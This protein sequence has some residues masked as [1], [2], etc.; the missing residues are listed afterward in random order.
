MAREDF[1]EQVEEALHEALQRPLDCRDEFVAGIADAEI[2]AEVKSL[3]AAEGGG[4]KL[5]IEKDIAEAAQEL[6]AEPVLRD[7]NIGHF[8]L[9]DLA[10]RGGMSQVY[11]ARDKHLGRKVA[12]KL[13]PRSLS[14]DTD[15]IRRFK[16][17]ARA[18]SAL[19]H[20]NIVTV[21]EIAESDGHLF[22]ATE[23]VAGETLEERLRR[24]HI[25]V[26][27]VL[28]VGRQLASALTAA[29]D[30]GI[31][32]R[33]I[34][35]GNIMI[36]SDGTLKLLD[37]GLARVENALLGGKL[38]QS[39]HAAERLTVPGTVFGT[40]AYMSP[41][42][43]KCEVVDLRTDLWSAGAVL[44]ELLSSHPAFAEASVPETLVAILNRQPPLP[45][46]NNQEVPE[47]LDRLV[48]KLL[49]KSREA[50]VSSS[51]E[52][53]L[54]LDELSRT[55]KARYQS[56]SPAKKRLPAYASRLVLVAIVGI[57]LLL[58]FYLGRRPSPRLTAIPAH[59]LQIDYWLTVQNLSVDGRINRSFESPG[60]ASLPPNCR[61]RFNVRSKQ[62]GYLY[63]LNEASTSISPRQLTNLFPS[64]F[65]N[66]GS[67]KAVANQ[68]LTTGWFRI[69]KQVGTETVWLIWAP[70]SLRPLDE[71]RSLM[72]AQWKGVIVEPEQRKAV[73]SLLSRHQSEAWIEPTGKRVR[74]SENGQI[75]VR[76]IEI[77]IGG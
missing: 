66:G 65:R 18:A 32:H 42:Q 56:V 40:P 24:G 20:P 9:L 34:K 61:F 44:Y 26:S 63:L 49:Q 58:T 19:N 77:N 28:S 74:L 72:N 12:L 55:E 17:E 67:A 4:P 1:W 2:Q 71:L 48:M 13:F 68:V 53:L 23:Y 46:Q 39:A 43:C 21:Y 76:K 57:C 45:S 25:P 27:E 8:E 16:Q 38:E 30:A 11:I 37:F 33:D 7:R 15:R 51:A 73:E 47:A 5:D 14:A 54:A 6:T 52:L 70:K 75:L 62:D 31:I 36:R 60:N 59:N 69:N 29:H 22:I 41:E 64:P 35:P 50:R 10:G 3:I